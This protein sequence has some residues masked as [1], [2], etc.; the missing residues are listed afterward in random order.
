MKFQLMN[1]Y[2]SELK[3]FLSFSNKSFWSE[4]NSDGI[5]T[6][7]VIIWL[8][9]LLLLPIETTPLLFNRIFLPDWMPFGIFSS[10]SPSNV[11]TFIESPNAA[12]AIFISS[13]EKISDAILSNFSWGVTW[14]E[15]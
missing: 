3:D 12:W 8:P 15:T 13:V 6:I 2:S 11:E 5:E 9:L 7:I 10:I 1:H 14:T 4:V